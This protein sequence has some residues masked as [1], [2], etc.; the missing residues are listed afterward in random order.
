MSETTTDIV[1]FDD[2]TYTYNDSIVLSAS[3]PS[4]RT[5]SYSIVTNTD[6]AFTLTT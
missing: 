3:V 6:N 5:P 1:N 2:E 4:E